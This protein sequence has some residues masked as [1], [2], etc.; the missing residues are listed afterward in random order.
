[1]VE[2]LVASG[3]KVRAFVLYNS[4]DS[5]GWLDTLSPAILKNVEFF[6]GDVRDPYGVKK[7]MKGCD[8]VLHLAAL[9]GIPYSYHSPDNYVDTNVKGTLNIVQ[10]AR[11]L[12]VKKIIHTSTSEVYGTARFVPITEAHPLIGQ[13]PYSATKIAADQIALS[14]Y[15]SF[16]LPVAVLRPFNTY[17][18]RQSTRA[19]I[20]TVIT[21]LLKGDAIKLGSLT[22]T[23]DFTY[24]EDTARAFVAALE[25]NGIEGQTL[26]V[27]SGFEISIKD[28]VKT[29]VKAAGVSVDIELDSNRKRPAKSEVERLWADSCKANKLLKWK[30][31]YG[32]L[33]GFEKG[34]AKTVEWFANP[35]NLRKYRIGSYT[36]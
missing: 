36:V 26:N 20:P 33:R 34:I 6:M 30:P 3:Y 13:S 9:I 4:F 24:V 29:I 31:K 22:P 1:M 11:E 12:G 10:A 28:V 16:G 8:G 19:V 15:Y 27:G 23:R 5:K 14:F 7:A 2:R 25:A 32:G 35:E 17:G 21:Q 18:P